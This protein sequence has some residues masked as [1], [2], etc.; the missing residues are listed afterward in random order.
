MAPDQRVDAKTRQNLTRA[1]LAALGVVFGDI[2]TSPLY[3]LKTVLAMTGAGSQHTVLGV[4]S[5]DRLDFDHRHLGQ[6]CRLRDAR[7]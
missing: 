2:G 7:R 6:I 1:G 3:T 5:L 4:L